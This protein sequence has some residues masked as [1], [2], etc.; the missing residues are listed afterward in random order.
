V[1]VWFW[2]SVGH[3]QNIFFSE[4]FVDE[5]AHAAGKDPFEF[6]R[7]LLGNAPRHKGVLE[8]A[9]EKAGWGS[10]L[11]QGVHRG[12]AVAYSFGSYV[13]EVAEVSLSPEGRPRVHRVVAAVDCGEV[14]NPEIVKRQVESAIAY[15]LTAALYGKITFKDGRVE[16]GNFDTY[17]MLRMSEMPKVEVHILKS[18]SHATGMGEPGLPPLAPAITAA[19]FKA[20]GKR[21][22][23]LPIDPA[24]LKA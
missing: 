7:G 6:R 19:I 14:V 4:S 12:I 2:R 10:P 21:I 20:T 17:P 24:E 23:K 1:Q 16:Q 3:S 15:G 22:R 9:A 13:A 18:S 5:L 8:L 11:P